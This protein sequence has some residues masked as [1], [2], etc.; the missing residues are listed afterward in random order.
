[1]KEDA[2]KSGLCFIYIDR[3]II[4]AFSMLFMN[5]LANHLYF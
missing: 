5:G 3:I 4:A 1:M 2:I